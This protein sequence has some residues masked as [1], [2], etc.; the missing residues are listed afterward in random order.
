MPLAK[1]KDMLHGVLQA[2][3]QKFTNTIHHYS[4]E[5]SQIIIKLNH[6][7]MAVNVLELRKMHYNTECFIVS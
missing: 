2:K 6:Y 5:A 4:K 1:N 3:M 7:Q